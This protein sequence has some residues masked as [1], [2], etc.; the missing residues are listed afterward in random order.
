MSSDQNQ[1]LARRFFDEM[2]NGRKLEIAT[3]LFTSGHAYHDPSAPTG[4]GPDGMKQVIGSYQTAFADA[5]WTVNELFSADGDR[6]IVL[7]TGSGTQSGELMGI[8]PTKKSV[9]V[10]GIWIL[11]CANGKIVESWNHWDSLG[12]LQQ[13]GVVPTLAAKS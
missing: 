13:L 8:A 2:C 1:K 9:R 10:D 12:M 4:P 7:W 11:K 5:K 6:V 3:E